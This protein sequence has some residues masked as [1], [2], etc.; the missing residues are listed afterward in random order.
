[1]ATTV[2][3]TDGHG[4]AHF[5]P[6]IY[7]SMTG[8]A[9]LTVLASLAF[10]ADGGPEAYVYVIVAGFILGSLALPYLIRRVRRDDSRPWRGSIPPAETGESLAGFAKRDFVAGRTR[11]SGREA[12]IQALLP[13]AAVGIGMALLA[14]AMMVATAGLPD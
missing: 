8:F 10:F 1:M 9:G 2:P 6:A 14:A 13:I 5:H 11:I 4:Q 3:N 12:A 7:W